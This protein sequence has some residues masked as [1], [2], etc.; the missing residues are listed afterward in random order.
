MTKSF[1]IAG[2]KR[3]RLQGYDYSSPGGYFI[4]QGTHYRRPYFANIHS[5]KCTLTDAGTM[6]R[7]V[8]YSLENRFFPFIALDAFVIMPDHI[9]GII[10]ISD[11]EPFAFTE[12][13]WSRTSP[14]PTDPSSSVSTPSASADPLSSVPAAL[15]AAES[16]GSGT[17]PDPTDPSSSVSTSSVS[18][19]PLSSVPTSPNQ[20]KRPTLFDVVG[21][22]KSITTVLYIRGV[23]TLGWAPFSK[24]LWQRMDYEHIIRNE[25]DLRCIR[26]YISENPLR[27]P[28]L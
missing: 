16:I 20:V 12:T 11:G 5:G 7:D 25:S 14:D 22:F 13:I 9:H 2:R 6:V 24:K 18:A 23:H 21:A 8:W 19:D 10:F 26:R 28:G 4:T 27:N 15:A 17:S 3:I 1:H